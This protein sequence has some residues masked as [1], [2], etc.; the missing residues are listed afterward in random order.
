MAGGIQVGTE[1]GGIESKQLDGDV[2]LVSE[3]IAKRITKDLHYEQGHKNMLAE[4]F[5]EETRDRNALPE[6]AKL[7][8]TSGCMPDGGMWFTG[9][10]E[11]STRKLVAVFEA[12][13]QQDGG[14]AIERWATNY[15]LCRRINS[16]VVYVTFMTGEGAKK[17]GVLH[18]YGT[19]MSIV[20][21]E[22]CRFHFSPNGFSRETIFEVMKSA[23]NLPFNFND[24]KR[25]LPAVPLT[26][27]ENQ[28]ILEKKTISLKL[29]DQF[30][31]LLKEID[32]P[33]AKVWALLNKSDIIEAKEVAVDFLSEGLNADSIAKE[34][35]D[36]YQV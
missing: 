24:I 15:L 4:G 2:K 36:L 7:G 3:A 21:G 19:D 17:G 31:Q 32:S 18:T 1:A 10:R 23:L 11:D 28:A 29:E 20:N 16:D 33:L 6:L 5:S 9:N 34:M 13:H 8:I 22:N 30:E 27:E 14:N 25:Y 26:A 12:K 35:Q